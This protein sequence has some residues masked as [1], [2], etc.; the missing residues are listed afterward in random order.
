MKAH[1]PTKGDVLKEYTQGIADRTLKMICITLINEFGFGQDR[2]AK[3]LSKTSEL[4]KELSEN[5]HRWVHID[6][7]LIGK[8]KLPFNSED[9]GE[10][11]LSAKVVRRLK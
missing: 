6:E 2:S 3:L 10:R 9:L 8:R 5:P 4:G 7:E 11:D 1:L